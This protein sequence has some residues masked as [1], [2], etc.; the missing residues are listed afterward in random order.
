MGLQETEPSGR[1]TEADDRIIYE[2]FLVNETPRITSVRCGRSLSAI[3]RR[4]VRLG[5]IDADGVRNMNPPF[6]A[7]LCAK[8][9][10]RTSA[11]SGPDDAANGDNP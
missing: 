7:D 6:F 8:H 4:L 3:R 5:L 10:D 9:H 1:W 11:G 2:G